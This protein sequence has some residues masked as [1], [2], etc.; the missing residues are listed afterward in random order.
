[1]LNSY[2]D[3]KNIPTNKNQMQNIAQ[4]QMQNCT[5]SY[6]TE[7]LQNIQKIKVFFDSQRYHI[8]TPSK[9]LIGK[10]TKTSTIQWQS[11]DIPA[12]QQVNA[13]NYNKILINK[14]IREC[15][16]KYTCL[17]QRK[18]KTSRHTS[19]TFTNILQALQT[20]FIYNRTLY[21]QKD[22]KFHKK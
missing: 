16:S 6:C 5:K 15:V 7:I 20:P 22:T 21:L 14:N 9:Y 8:S 11:H 17:Q 2:K 4:N 18:T 3:E 19:L 10:I 13:R 12:S 1:M